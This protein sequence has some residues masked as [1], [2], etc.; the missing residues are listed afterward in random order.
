MNNKSGTQVV[1]LQGEKTGEASA[2]ESEKKPS[3][4]ETQEIVKKEGGSPLSSGESAGSEFKVH[5]SKAC[6]DFK[7]VGKEVEEAS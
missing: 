6:I 5:N 1:R 3:P 4:R 2:Q 7:K